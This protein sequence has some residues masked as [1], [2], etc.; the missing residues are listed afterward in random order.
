MAP[1]QGARKNQFPPQATSPTTRP[2]PGTSRATPSRWRRLA[3]FS[4][5]TRPSAPSSV[6]TTPTGVSIRCRPGAIRPRRPSASP[7]P[8]VPADPGRADVVEEEAAGGAARIRGRQ[9]RGPAHR[10]GAARLA[11]HRRAELVEVAAEAL[12]PL[13]ERAV[14]ERRP[15]GDDGAGGLAAGVG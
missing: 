14:A 13:G 6:A 2:T 15:A 10:V 1:S 7:T 12:A 5:V 8:V 9:E 4:T 11:A 3:T